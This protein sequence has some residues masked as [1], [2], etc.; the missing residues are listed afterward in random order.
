MG[1]LWEMEI[2]AETLLY[3]TAA[4]QYL[5]RSYLNSDARCTAICVYSGYSEIAALRI[6]GT[7]RG[8]TRGLGAVGYVRQRRP[9]GDAPLSLYR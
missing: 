4:V 6:Q 2:S 5:L 8:C 9:G 1:N 7:P 3:C